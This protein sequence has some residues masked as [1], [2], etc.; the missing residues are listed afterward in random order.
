MGQMRLKSAKKMRKW[1]IE[2]LKSRK[3]NGARIA[4]GRELKSPD[5]LQ[6]LELAPQ[7]FLFK[8]LFSGQVLLSQVPAYHQD[9]IDVQFPNPNWQDRRPSRR[10]D[11]WKIMCIANFNNYEYATAA[12]EGLLQL[13]KLRQVSKDA[14]D[15]RRK[16]EE[17]N[18]WFSGQFRPTYSQEAVADL[19][20]VIDEFELEGT[21][22]FWENEWRKGDEKYWNLDLVEHDKLP[23]HSPNQQTV[24]LDVMRARA[25]EEFKRQRESFAQPSQAV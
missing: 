2:Q 8:N 23:V 24:L 4:Q 21:R 6:S 7:V 3:Q 15:M 20:H 9:Q 17:G 1:Y 11:L 12:Y 14:N 25:M 19:A 13:K 16:N 5:E 10:Q 18:I 22:L